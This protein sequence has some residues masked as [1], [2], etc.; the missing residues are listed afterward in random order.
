VSHTEA[1]EHTRAGA[2]IEADL[3]LLAAAAIWGAGFVPGR[4]ASV[5]LGP[6]FYN[7]TRFLTGL[8]VLL[9]IAGRRMRGLT[10]PDV[11]AGVAGGLVMALA[12]N[13]QQMGLQYTTAGKAGFITGLYVVM[14]PIFAAIVDW[15]LLHWSV[16]AASLVS[17]VALF[18]LSGLERLALAPGDAWVLVGAMFWAVHIVLVS[19]VLPRADA[20]RFSVVQYAVCGTLSTGLG[21]LLEPQSIPGLGHAWWAVA[22][23]GVMSVGVAFTLQI[24]GQRH[25]PPADAAV[26]LSSESVFAALFGWIFL[27]EYLT[28]LQLLGCGMMLAAMLLAQW[29]AFR[30]G[31]AAEG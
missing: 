19:K 7:G 20:L 27:R 9:P 12:A 21:L 22:F 29:Q 31:A 1:R 10:R 24:L 11:W 15:K 16:W 2:R 28:P 5:H 17:T 14:V 26:L 6:L 13:P 18:L 8:L 3:M 4:L 25:A 30:S 23:N